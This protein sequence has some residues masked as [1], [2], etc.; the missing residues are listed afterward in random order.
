MIKVNKGEYLLELQ[1]RI[2]KIIE[3]ENAL[4]VADLKV[5]GHDVMR[6]LKIKPGPAVGKLLNELL[7]K[8]LDD[9]KLNDRETLLNLIKAHA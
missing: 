6:V 5:D 4:H 3:A 9:P 7:E 2:D 1:K 8:V